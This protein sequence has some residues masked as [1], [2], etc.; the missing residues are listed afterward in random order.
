MKAAYLYNFAK[1]A[2]WPEQS[3]PQGAPLLIGIV[4]GD[5][6]FIDTVTKTVSGKTAGTHA[7]A[8][9]RA[10]T[11]ADISLCHLFFFAPPPDTSERKAQLPERGPIPAFYG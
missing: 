5:D 2:E 11:D 10:E 7:I 8:A 9:K 1:A 4:G 3:L 6:E